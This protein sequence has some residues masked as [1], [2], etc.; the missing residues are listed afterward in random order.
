M[1][2]TTKALVC[3]KEIRQSLDGG[4]R[5]NWEKD[6]KFSLAFYSVRASFHRMSLGTDKLKFGAYSEHA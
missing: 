2:T 5:K 6:L 1:F 3:G 4:G